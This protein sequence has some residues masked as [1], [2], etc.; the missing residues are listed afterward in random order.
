M[1]SIIC[2]L[3]LLIIIPCKEVKCQ[4]TKVDRSKFFADTSIINVHIATDLAKIFKEKT[5]IGIRFPASFSASSQEGDNLNGNIFL[6]IRGHFRR[7]YC[8]L[9]PLRVIFGHKKGPGIENLGTLKLVS[10][11]RTT[12]TDQQYLLKEYLIYKIYNLIT[13]MSFRVRLLHLTITDSTGRKKPID[14]YGYFMEDIKDL[15]KR[16]KCKEYK[17]TKEDPRLTDSRQMATVAIFEYMIGNTDW[18]VYSNHNT[19]LIRLKKDTLQA[20]FVVPYDF[21]F[22]GFVN[23][24]YSI[25]DEKLQI[26]NVRERLY[27]G[28]PKPLAEINEVVDIFKKEKDS[29][30]QM[31]D[32]FDLLNSKSKKDLKN[33]LDGFFE[34]IKNP[35]E[36]KKVFIY[37][38]RAD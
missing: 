2:S 17:N 16:N 38:A 8:Y 36:V 23:T 1:K 32:Q 9:P 4:N 30:Y 22:S 33:Y 14:E 20:P 27:R 25:P 15:A 12:G 11:C 6:E 24:D 29:I 10:Q 28:F 18:A 5:R 31:I 37:N 13:D 26:A 34:T 3:L 7:D 21:D 35:Q 19:R